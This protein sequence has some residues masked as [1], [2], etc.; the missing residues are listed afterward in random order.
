MMLRC[1]RPHF[2]EKTAG[3]K[4]DDAGK[5]DWERQ[6]GPGTAP[7]KHILPPAGAPEG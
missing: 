4:K 3:A 6:A 5:A 7:K 1:N 2:H